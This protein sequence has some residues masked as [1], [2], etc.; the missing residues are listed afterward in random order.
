MAFLTPAPDGSGGSLLHSYG[1]L[2]SAS[3]SVWLNKLF[4]F[5]AGGL[6]LLAILVVTRGRGMGFGDVKLA[7]ALGAL[8]GWPDVAVLVGISFVLGALAGL[9]AMATGGTT[10]KSALP[11]G[12]FL[13]LA[14]AFVFF[15]GFEFVR[16][17]LAVFV[18]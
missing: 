7:A 15:T 6:G 13:A 14:G 1:I 10:L 9:L 4:G 12:P 16:W 3:S 5:L 17:Y 2:L 18:G 8:F 11:F